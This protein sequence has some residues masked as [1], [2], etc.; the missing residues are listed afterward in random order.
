MIYKN[1]SDYAPAPEKRKTEESKTDNNKSD[2]GSSKG[3]SAASYGQSTTLSP[4]ISTSLINSERSATDSSAAANAKALADEWQKNRPVYSGAKY[5]DEIES[6]LDI[7]SDMEFSYDAESDPVYRA[8]RDSY[9]D[10]ARLA[11]QDAI[12]KSAAL[13]GGMGNSYAQAAGQQAYGNTVSKAVQ[14]I[15]ELYEA[16]WGRY[17]DEKDATAQQIKLLSELDDAD[18]ERYNDMLKDYLS[19]GKMLTDNYR[20]L[21]KDDWNRY[22]DYVKLLLS[23]K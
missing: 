15:P 3:S 2:S 10:Q 21:S 8:Y 23:I 9:A 12:G 19:E 5:A 18:F 13:T 14:I 16:A 20:N 6:L 1:S 7:L 22:T 11:M 4:L 17:T